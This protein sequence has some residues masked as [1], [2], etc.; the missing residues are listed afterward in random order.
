MAPRPFRY[1]SLG[2][3]TAALLAPSMVLAQ[4]AAPANTSTSQQVS[5][6]AAQAQVP[7]LGEVIVTAQRRQENIE[8]VPI[9]VAAVSAS[10]LQAANVT[11]ISDLPNVVP[12]LTMPTTAGYTL[13]HLRGV[14]ITAVGPGIENSVA[15]YVDGVY[16]GVASSDDLALN[17][18]KQVEVEYGPQGTLFGRNATGG[19][20]Q[21]TTLDPRPGF[22]GNAS[23]G[24]G[25][26][27]T[28]SA[29]AYLTGGTD[30]LAGDLA[31]TSTHQGEGYGRNIATGEDVNRMDLDLSVRSKWLLRP[32]DGT[33]ITLILD[34]SETRNSLSALRN[35]DSVANTYY[36]GTSST[37]PALDVNDSAQPWRD[38]K[39]D[40]VSLQL[41]QAV[42]AL[43][44]RNIVA[45]RQDLYRYNV[46]FDLGP[47]PYSVND[48]RQSDNQ[49]TDEL[50]L[51][52]ARDARVTW[53]VGTYIYNAHDGYRPQDLYF[54]G[55]AVNPLKPVTHIDNQSQLNTDSVALYAQ[56]TAPLTDRT[57]LTLGA[58]YTDEKRGLVAD[59]TGY[60]NG[61]VPV[62]LAAPD[63]SFR[64]R[65][66]TWRIALSHDFS[67][68]LLGYISYNRGYKSGGYNVPAPAL[69]AY[70]P[71][72]LDAYEAGMKAQLLSHRVTV[73][74]SA[75]YYNYE[76]I[77]VSR[78]LN[79]SQEVYN[80]G[81]ARLY[82]IDASAASRITERLTVTAG[83]ELEHTR[84]TDFPDADFF[85]SCP[86]PYPTV[87]SNSANGKQL[88]QAPEASATLNADY[89][90]PL[91]GGSARLN[92]NASANSGYYFAPN[93]EYKQSGYGLLD[94]SL[95]WSRD[96]FTITLWG[97][98]L[99]D[100]IYPIAVNQA[101]TAVAAAYAA[102]RTYGLTL[103][104]DF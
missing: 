70:R 44:L 80:G 100:R 72:K 22:S 94:A 30:I 45:Y 10:T 41:D 65:T 52:S 35:Y 25:N 68:D 88:P 15:L 43:T 56:A 47:L 78:F 95:G 28:V 75:F 20:I 98:N 101:P 32:V 3:F 99:T 79:G 71:E 84:F 39:D 92:V 85:L 67:Q 58:R 5:A 96:L 57:R 6:P 14:G 89:R 2:T 46:D 34:D 104:V 7:T 53:I 86:A 90:A 50:Q 23:V 55:L 29:S 97:K 93:N 8:H 12:G 59:E 81:K 49:L 76:N 77:Q 64:N 24:Y 83:M 74:T 42:G 54:T 33:R 63:T 19:L 62:T 87:C 66:P 51:L 27:D 31:V 21:I 4:S 60:V 1:R 26:Y 18:I 36:P 16:R 11:E 17:N 69:P 40:G 73:N 9:T 91:F 82:G 13:P 38:M 48:V 61:V 102:P 37:L 103:R